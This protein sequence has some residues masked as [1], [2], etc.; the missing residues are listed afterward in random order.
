[1]S[2]ATFDESRS[3]ELSR[4]LAAALPP[5]L[6]LTDLMR[7]GRASQEWYRVTRAEF[8]RRAAAGEVD[9]EI[10]YFNYEIMQ[11][12]DLPLR[13]STAA[14][15]PRLGRWLIRQMPALIA[16]CCE[17]EELWCYWMEGQHVRWARHI[18][19]TYDI[20]SCA[21]DAMS[22][23]M[24]RW[25]SLAA[26]MST[27]QLSCEEDNP[28]MLLFAALDAICTDRRNRFASLY[29]GM[30]CFHSQ[31]MLIDMMAARRTYPRWVVDKLRYVDT[32]RATAANNGLVCAATT[33]TS[34]TAA[35]NISDEEWNQ[36]VANITTCYLYDRVFYRE[37]ETCSAHYH[38]R[39]MFELLLATFGREFI[40]RE[41]LPHLDYASVARLSCTSRKWN[42][43]VM[44]YI[45]AEPYSDELQRSRTADERGAADK[46]RWYGPTITRAMLAAGYHMCQHSIFVHAPHSGGWRIEHIPLISQVLFRGALER[47]WAAW[48]RRAEFDWVAALPFIPYRT[49][50]NHD[51]DHV[52]QLHH[53]PVMEIVTTFRRAKMETADPFELYS[54]AINGAVY[55]FWTSFHQ[56]IK[57][58][59]ARFGPRLIG[60]IADGLALSRAHNQYTD[61][62][63]RYPRSAA[64]LP[65]PSPP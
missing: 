60:I 54:S 59:S 2:I 53:E 63:A 35:V 29:H 5:F 12:H 8:R 45:V 61:E 50:R 46:I 43:F 52:I 64:P 9:G 3:H 58:S 11:L 28:A 7:A 55:D 19:M 26:T 14:D 20:A 39:H 30:L 18:P 42:R 31:R 57:V 65:L 41:I 38:L 10:A 4:T 44:C 16:R 34:A 47:L 1:M 24:K 17:R 56:V 13:A 37:F 25:A 15:I 6:P 49:S 33:I 40:A 23:G 36:F 51:R 62:V 48:L 32:Y 27:Q 22:T 21:G